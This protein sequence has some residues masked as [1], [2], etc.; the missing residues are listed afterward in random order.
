MCLSEKEYSKDI[1]LKPE[2]K[3]IQWSVVTACLPTEDYADVSASGRYWTPLYRMT[4][5]CDDR[6]TSEFREIL[7]EKDN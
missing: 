4:S 5:E 7:D 1:Q 6:Y 2:V 3:K